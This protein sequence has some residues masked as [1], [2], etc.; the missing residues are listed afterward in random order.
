MTE[1]FTNQ[2][3][4]FVCGTFVGWFAA[5]V[6]LAYLWAKKRDSCLRWLHKNSKNFGF[7]PA[8]HDAAATGGDDSQQESK[9]KTQ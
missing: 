7:E 1:M 6:L 8:I 5:K 3:V 9:A 4:T 2:A